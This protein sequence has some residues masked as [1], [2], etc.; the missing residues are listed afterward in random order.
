M[1]DPRIADV[2]DFWL[3]AVGPKGWFKADPAVDQEIAARFGALVAA[4]AAGALDDWAETRDGALALILLLDQ[5]PRNLHRGAPGAFAADAQARAVARAALEAGFDRATPPSARHFFY[6]PFEH[7]EDLADQDLAVTLCAERLAETP[8]A[9]RHAELHRDL[10]RRFGR[11]PHRNA[12]LG[13]TP[14]D[15]E[16]AHLDGG[17]YAPGARGASDKDDG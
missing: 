15:A 13:R 6:L 12:A 16:R 4:A 10:I 17:G 14:T 8:D 3:S 11:F 1:S 2:L 9:L 5:F 7:S